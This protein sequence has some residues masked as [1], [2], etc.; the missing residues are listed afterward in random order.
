MFHPLTKDVL[1]HKPT[2]ILGCSPGKLSAPHYSD[3]NVISSRLFGY[4]VCLFS[5]F[6]NYEAGFI[7]FWWVG[8]VFRGIWPCF[9]METEAYE[10]MIESYPSL[11]PTQNWKTVKSKHIGAQRGA[12][13]PTTSFKPFILSPTHTCPFVCPQPFPVQWHLW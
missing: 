1:A 8:K 6:E 4:L 2:L 5:I 11:F 13:V 7:S 9:N 3:I 10:A 12:L